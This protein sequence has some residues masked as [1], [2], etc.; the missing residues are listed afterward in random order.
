MSYSLIV[1]DGTIPRERVR[2][3]ERWPELSNAPLREI[4][5]KL[6]S[7]TRALFPRRQFALSLDDK[8]AMDEMTG[9]TRSMSNW[10]A[11]WPDSIPVKLLKVDHPEFI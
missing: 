11:V 10:K 2:I 1:E 7:M 4:S 3:S 5:H 9:I 6:D 8:P